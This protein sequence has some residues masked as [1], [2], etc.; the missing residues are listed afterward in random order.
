MC[1]TVVPER[2]LEEGGEVKYLASSPGGWGLVGA[3]KGFV[4][5]GLSLGVCGG[6]SEDVGGG[7]FG[8]LWG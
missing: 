4:G 8:G 2:S 5:G 1:H 3:E 6:D 7:E